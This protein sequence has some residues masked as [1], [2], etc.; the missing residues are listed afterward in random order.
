MLYRPFIRSDH[1]VFPAQLQVGTYRYMSPEELLATV[2]LDSTEAFK[3]MD[4]YSMALV[5]WEVI[6]RCE[7]AGERCCIAWLA[8]T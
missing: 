5:L 7:A 6:S 2:G 1:F 4:I 8:F 3:Q